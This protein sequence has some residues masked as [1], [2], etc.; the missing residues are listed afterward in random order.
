MAIYFLF[1][2]VY[3]YSMKIYDTAKEKLVNL[4][5]D[6]QVRIYT[7]GI[8]PYDSA[9][10]GHIFTFMTYD[11]LSRRLIDL[12]HDVRLVRNVTDVDEPIFKK[13]K[14]LNISYKKLA[15]DETT[16]FQ[17]VLKKLNFLPAY[18]EPLAS[19]YISEMAQAV[20]V[21]LERGFAY[22]LES[23]IY[24]SVDKLKSF[25]TFSNLNFRLQRNFMAMRGG[26]INRVGKNNPLDFLLWRGVNDV[27]DEA[28]WNEVVGRGRPGWHIE[29]SVMSQ[30]VLGNPFDLHGGGSD[31]IFPHHECEIAQS[32]GLG[33]TKMAKYWMHV[34]PMLFLGEKMSKSLGNLVFAGDLLEKYHPAVIR[35]ALMDYHYTNGGEWHPEILDV[36]KNLFERLNQ[37]STKID[38]KHANLLLNRLRIAMDNNIDNHDIMHALEDIVNIK[39]FKKETSGQEIFNKAMWLLGLNLK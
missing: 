30:A 4:K 27:K 16:K 29:C 36:C 6:H 13:A 11:L 21:L 32:Y 7:C 18:A 23:D 38:V 28:V 14:E 8:T 37:V 9:H 2:V 33:Q 12:G 17:L 39:Q 22:R 1:Y 34:S 20:N 31:L 35:L 3:L 15:A 19:E 25:G 26:D 5:L 24:F 10:L